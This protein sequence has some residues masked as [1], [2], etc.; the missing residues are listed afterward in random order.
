MMRL[1]IALGIPARAP[2]GRVIDRLTGMGPSVRPVRV[3]HLHL[4]LRFLGDVTPDQLDP[5]A[6][7]IDSA[8]DAGLSDGW[9]GPFDLG[10]TCLGT[11]PDRADTPRVLFAHT[12]E[13]DSLHRLSQALD[14]ELDALGLPIP[15]RDHPFSPHVTLARFRRTR[16]PN[17]TVR[18]TLGTMI[19]ESTAGPG[20]GSV[21]VKAVKLIE[22]RPGTHGPAYITRHSR[23]LIRTCAM[24]P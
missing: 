17:R 6:G 1:F 3:T 8:V 12:Q 13:L 2:L 21:R 20:L 18:D 23:T 11:F 19:A 15:P 14:A 16:R 9:L 22:S 24:G 10:L 7:A 4:T 5:I